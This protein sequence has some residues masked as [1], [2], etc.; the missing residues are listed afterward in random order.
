MELVDRLDLPCEPRDCMRFAR[1]R[2]HGIKSVSASRV[3]LRSRFLGYGGFNT[4]ENI[5]RLVTALVHVSLSL[6]AATSSDAPD[7]VGCLI[8]LPKHSDHFPGTILDGNCA[9]DYELQVPVDKPHCPNA[10]P[11][12]MVLMPKCASTSFLN[13]LVAA[14]GT[15]EYWRKVAIDFEDQVYG[16]CNLKQNGKG[17]EMGL[18]D[19]W[20]K[21]IEL[22]R[23]ISHG[24]PPRGTQASFDTLEG[25][26]EI[27]F[28]FGQKFHSGLLAYPMNCIPCC[29]LERPRGSQYSFHSEAATPNVRS[30]VP[31][32][33]SRNPFT[34]LMAYFQR[35]WLNNDAKAVTTME[36]FPIWAE[37]IQILRDSG[38]L[39]SAPRQ[40]ERVEIHV[41]GKTLTF[42]LEDLYHTRPMYNVLMDTFPQ[43]VQADLSAVLP[44]CL[45][46][47]CW[48][49]RNVFVIHTET[50]AG[51]FELL[52][53]RLCMKEEP[54]HCGPL[55]KVL[56]LNPRSENQHT[57]AETFWA[58]AGGAEAAHRLADVYSADFALGNYDTDPL[59]FSPRNPPL[60]EV[61]DWVGMS[62]AV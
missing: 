19:A 3:F 56:H 47:A 30:R 18:D 58:S 8:T 13:W 61:L 57:Q 45:P 39:L 43:Q 29:N 5:A 9:F 33:I 24:I 55:P 59:S 25:Q 50:I 6:T 27:H 53:F 14:D 12:A 49:V 42:T 4:L 36:E 52:Q 60:A 1:Q 46:V 11:I 48:F 20:V 38:S 40:G 23:N 51:D 7:Q 35:A 17:C 21:S 28:R 15:A 10:L 32:V 2:F 54:R 16:E 44:S 26:R 22:I 34:R 31:V 41:R 37:A 62:A